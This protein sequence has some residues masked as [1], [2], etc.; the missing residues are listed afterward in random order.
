[1][2]AWLFTA[3]HEPLRF[4]PG[5]RWSYSTAGIDT[6]SHVVE[7]VSGMP[8]AQFMQQNILDPLGMTNTTYWL[9]PEQFARY[10]RSY[11]PDPAT[12]KLAETTIP[13]MYDGAVTDHARP[14]LGGAGMFSTATESARLT[15]TIDCEPLAAPVWIDRDQ[16]AKIILNLLSNALKFT[17]EGGIGVRLRQVGE[18]IELAVSDTGTGIPERELEHLFERFHRVHGAQSRSY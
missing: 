4:Q 15:L 9:S 6:L 3:A 12:G 13:F 5:T 1:M 18:S 16:W 8:F 2:R 14:A 11:H 17:F 7:V 10:A